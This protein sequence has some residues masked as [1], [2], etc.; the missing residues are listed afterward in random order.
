MKCAN[1]RRDTQ[2]P[3]FI[4]GCGYGPVC[5]LKFQPEPQRRTRGL[6]EPKK[7]RV[8]LFTRTR[9]ARPDDPQLDLLQQLE[10]T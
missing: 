2:H 4:N 8:R 6:F 7:K 1:C 10:C 9:K 3:V 5:A